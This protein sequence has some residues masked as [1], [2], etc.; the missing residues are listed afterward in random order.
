MKMEHVVVAPAA[1]RVVEVAVD[2]GRQVAR[3]DLV[4]MVE[5]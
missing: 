5:G 4:A 2:A 3:G 1:G